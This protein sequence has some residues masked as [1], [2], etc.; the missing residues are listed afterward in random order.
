MMFV[1][2][3]SFRLIVG[4]VEALIGLLPII[5]VWLAKGASVLCPSVLDSMN[6][7]RSFRLGCWTMIPS[8]Q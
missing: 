1:L 3:L 6:I 2:N 7:V 8:A 5:A 4:A